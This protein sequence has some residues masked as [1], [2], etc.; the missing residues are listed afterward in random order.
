MVHRV[1]KHLKRA[2]IPGVH[3]EEAYTITM[4]KTWKFHTANNTRLSYSDVDE[5]IDWCNE[6]CE[7]LVYFQDDDDWVFEFSNKNDATA[8]KLRW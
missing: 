4:E 5:L 2:Y 8:F 6:N 7:N 3:K 1:I